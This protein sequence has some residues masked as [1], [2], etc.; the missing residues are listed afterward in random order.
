MKLSLVA[1]L[2]VTIAGPALAQAPAPSWPL[3]PSLAAT[4]A[5]MPERL[6]RAKAPPVGYSIDLARAAMDACTAKG[7]K[8]SVLVTDSLGEPVVLLSGDGA[9]VRSAL[10]ARAKSNTVAKY[11]MPDREVQAKAKNDPKLMAEITANPDIGAVRGGAFPLMSG[12][13]M[14]GILSVSGMFT[15]GVDDV[16]AKEAMA[17]VPLH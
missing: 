3:Q 6:P 5:A 15:G 14:I 16:C 13:E 9:A 1:A 7:G 10:V 4:I 11:K 2:S 8:V 12:G 17:K